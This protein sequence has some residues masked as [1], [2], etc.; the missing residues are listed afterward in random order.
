MKMQYISSYSVLFI[1]IVLLFIY[2]ILRKHINFEVT[3]ILQYFYCCAQLR[4]HFSTI[5]T[6]SDKLIKL[7]IWECWEEIPYLKCQNVVVR[8]LITT[9]CLQTRRSC[10]SLVL[11]TTDFY[12]SILT[13][14]LE[15]KTFGYSTA[16]V[17]NFQVFYSSFYW[18]SCLVAQIKF[19]GM[20]LIIV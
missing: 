18:H 4:L 14:S 17:F 7:S 8:R 10:L 11:G 6:W 13:P 3:F 5:H 2:G 9:W 19:I 15:T 12:F 16:Y 20:H 1:D